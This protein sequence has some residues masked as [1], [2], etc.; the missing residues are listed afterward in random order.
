MLG[1]KL[2]LQLNYRISNGYIA[3]KARRMTFRRLSAFRSA[4]ETPEKVKTSHREREQSH[5]AR[6]QEALA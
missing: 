2:S 5:A 3:A 6:T 4:L 1:M